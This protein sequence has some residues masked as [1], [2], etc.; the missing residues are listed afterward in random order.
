MDREECS[1]CYYNYGTNACMY[2]EEG[3]S[4]SHPMQCMEKS[5]VKR[6]N[7]ISREQG[8]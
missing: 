1:G 4:D 2:G 5:T 6:S 8:D 7:V 3:V